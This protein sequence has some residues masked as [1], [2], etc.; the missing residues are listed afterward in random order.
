MCK[1]CDP[2]YALKPNKNGNRI[3]DKPVMECHRDLE[4]IF[5]RKFPV[6]DFFS[7]FREDFNIPA[8]EEVVVEEQEASGV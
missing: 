7:D 8:I 6:E 4:A 5:D 2:D 3:E 1:S